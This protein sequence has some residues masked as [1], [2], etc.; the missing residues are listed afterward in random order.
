VAVAVKVVEELGATA[1]LIPK[2]AAL[3]TWTANSGPA[4]AAAA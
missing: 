3:T 1:R 4:Q 2:A